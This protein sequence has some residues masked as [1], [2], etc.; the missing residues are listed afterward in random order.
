[1]CLSYYYCQL[2][3]AIQGLPGSILVIA[4][5]N[6]DEGLTGYFTKY[7][8][9]SGDLNPIGSISKM[10]LRQFVKYFIDN[11]SLND[12]NPCLQ[13]YVRAVRTVLF[14]RFRFRI[15]DAV[16]SAELVP[17]QEGKVQTDEEEMGITYE[18]LDRFGKLRSKYRCGPYSM[19]TRL[20]NHSQP[21]CNHNNARA[22]YER[23]RFFFISSF[24]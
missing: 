16:P 3:A 4:T 18:E 19:F 6:C 2:V 24:G 14:L 23:V 9:S 21:S 15:L 1:M 12:D 17:T 5:G 20:L 13:E 8:C 22:V 10:E 11:H 7:D